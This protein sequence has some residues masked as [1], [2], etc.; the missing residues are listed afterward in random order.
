[1]YNGLIFSPASVAGHD[2]WE[3][4]HRIQ[5]GLQST[6]HDWVSGHR[7]LRQGDHNSDGS[8]TGLGTSD[9]VFRHQF[10]AWREYMSAA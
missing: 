10:A 9:I 3:A 6:S 2:D 5:H 8:V 4:Y 7:H 1:M